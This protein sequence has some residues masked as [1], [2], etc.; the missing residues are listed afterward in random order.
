VK[1]D[2]NFQLTNPENHLVAVYGTLRKGFHNNYLLGDSKFLGEAEG[3]FGSVMFSCGGFPKLDLGKDL[4]LPRVKVEIYEVTPGI[5]EN[6]LDRLEG[7][8]D[9]YDRSV[10]PFDIGTDEVVRAWIYH[11]DVEGLPVVHSND[12]RKVR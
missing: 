3:D 6:N 5:L 7:Y 12:W 10:M 8:P 9:W 4:G 2:F 1:P 11:Q